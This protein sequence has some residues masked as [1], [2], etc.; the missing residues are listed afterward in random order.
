[1]DDRDVTPLTKERMSEILLTLFLTHDDTKVDHINALLEHFEG[2]YHVLLEK[3]ENRYGKGSVE[4]AST[5]HIALAEEEE[6]RKK[7]EEAEKKRIED[8]KKEK[9]ERYLKMKKESDIEKKMRREKQRRL[10]RAR[11]S[12]DREKF[13]REVDLEVSLTWGPMR[14][15]AFRESLFRNTRAGP[16]PRARRILRQSGLNW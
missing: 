11:R 10:D 6:Q 13:I 2:R 3:L 16:S 7:E 5:D 12:E 1:M 4:A 15:E 9:L 8:E 14:P